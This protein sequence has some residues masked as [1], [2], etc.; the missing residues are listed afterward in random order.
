M[1]NSNYC[2]RFGKNQIIISFFLFLGLNIVIYGLSPPD[3]F[4]AQ[5]T[6]GY[7]EPAQL[8]INEDIYRSDIRLPGYPI[9]LAGILLKSRLKK[10]LNS[11]DSRMRGR[12]PA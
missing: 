4:I 6:K 10:R 8:L 2:L 5:D 9:M 1:I 12:K 3:S 7:L 11:L